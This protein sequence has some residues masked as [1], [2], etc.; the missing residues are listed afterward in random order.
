MRRGIMN[1]A[2]ALA[3]M[4]M[5]GAC[6][7]DP[8]GFSCR[9]IAEDYCLQQWEDGFTYYLDDDRAPSNDGG[10]ALD[11]RVFQIGWND[12]FIVAQRSATSGGDL[13]WMVVDLRTRAVS[14]PY[15]WS[16]LSREQRTLQIMSPRAAWAKL[17]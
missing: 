3:V 5:A 10:G 6:D 13:G 8:F 17:D 4:T 7:L 11:G 14:G 16:Q 2:A 15:Q 9:D 12:R 1:L